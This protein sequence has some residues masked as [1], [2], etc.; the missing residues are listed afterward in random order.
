ML[1][2]GTR[3]EIVDM[4]RFNTEL[5][6]E[7]IDVKNAPGGFPLVIAHPLASRLKQS[8]RWVELKKGEAIA[9]DSFEP[10]MLGKNIHRSPRLAM[11][12]TYCEGKSGQNT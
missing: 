7:H 2:E 1:S 6:H 10:H 5:L 9:F 12:I 3:T 11:K 4:N 8:I